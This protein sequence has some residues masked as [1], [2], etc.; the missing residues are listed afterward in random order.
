MRRTIVLCALLALVAAGSAAAGN[1]KKHDPTPSVVY[2][3]YSSTF[4]ATP[5][6]ATAIAATGATPVTLTEEQAKAPLG[7]MIC[8][9]SCD[10]GGWHPAGCYGMYGEHRNN[11]IEY[12]SYWVHWVRYTACYVG[13]YYGGGIYWVGDYDTHVDTSGFVSADNVYI[14]GW[15]GEGLDWVCVQGHAEIYVGPNIGG[16]GWHFGDD[17]QLYSY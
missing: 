16:S 13:P 17:V 7:D 4:T 2:T 11:G 5:L 14:A 9:G 10:S 8:G 6:D 15:C 12:F 3:S 1:G